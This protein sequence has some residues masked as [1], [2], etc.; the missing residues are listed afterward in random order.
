MTTALAIYAA[1]VATCAI[2]WQVY[3][4][5][6]G[7]Q[8]HVVVTV[9]KAHP[10]LSDGTVLSMVAIKAVSKTSHPLR[11]TNSAIDAESLPRQTWWAVQPHPLSS[12]PG[13]IAPFD[14]GEAFFDAE[15]LAEQRIDLKKPIRGGIKLSTDDM[16]WSE[17]TVLET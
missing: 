12:I 15:K 5:R 17:P 11:A 14:S 16:I 8:I 9:S 4:W 6:H 2:S 3:T 13:V 1:V 7:R 10:I